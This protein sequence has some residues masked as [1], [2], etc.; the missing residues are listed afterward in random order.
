MNKKSVETR[1]LRIYIDADDWACTEGVI[2][3]DPDSTFNPEDYDHYD[4][5][6]EVTVPANSTCRNPECI[7]QISLIK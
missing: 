2:V 4:F 1:T 6:L 5:Y 3:D 7:G